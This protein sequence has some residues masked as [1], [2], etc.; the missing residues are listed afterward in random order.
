MVRRD[1]QEVDD[2]GQARVALICLHADPTEP[3]GVGGA[4]G[5]HSYLREL[6]GYL[7]SLDCEHILLTR[8]TGIDLPEHER[9]SATGSVHRLQIGP[10]APMD[11]RLL[12]LHHAETVSR[13]GE[14]LAIWGAPTLIHSVYWNSGQAAM[15][16][17]AATGIPFVHTVISN[18]WRREVCGYADQGSERIPIETRV[19]NAAR[20][21][22]CIC[23]QEKADLVSAYQVP[24][25]RIVVVGRPVASCFVDPA[26]D[27]LGQPR[28]KRLNVA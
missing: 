10:L 27:G 14:A 19:Y 22:F 11:K 25:E 15:D 1:S 9:T 23:S 24:A 6:L 8:R 21:V 2:L 16:Y 17:S 4:G 12:S 3:P 26:H 5:T 7:D 20:R 18:G 28:R 13:V